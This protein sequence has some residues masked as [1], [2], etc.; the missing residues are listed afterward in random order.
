MEGKRVTRKISPLR[1]I[2]QDQ[3]KQIAHETPISKITRAKWPGGMT[4][5]LMCLLS[6]HK[7]VSSNPSPT[8]KKLIYDIDKSIFLLGLL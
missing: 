8:K 5:V 6:K 7:D 4:H 1:I 3:S 2:V